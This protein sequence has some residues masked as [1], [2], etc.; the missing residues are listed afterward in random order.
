[1]EKSRYLQRLEEIMAELEQ[2]KEILDRFR[3]R[4]PGYIEGYTDALSDMDFKIRVIKT[5][6]EK[7]E[8]EEP[9]NEA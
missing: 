5:L 9:G 3:D 1:M 8:T 6:V 4:R 7:I 2:R